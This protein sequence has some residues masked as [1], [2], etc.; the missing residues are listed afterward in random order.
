MPNASDP[1]ARQQQQPQPQ[2]PQQ[3]PQQQPQYQ[4]PQPGYGYAGSEANA[5][6]ISSDDPVIQAIAEATAEASRRTSDPEV[7]IEQKKI[8]KRIVVQ[9]NSSL[10]ELQTNAENGTFRITD[11]DIWRSQTRYSGNA[12]RRSE[13]KKGN[14]QNV[15]LHSIRRISYRNDFPCDIGM[16]IPGIRTARGNVFMPDGDRYADLFH[17]DSFSDASF[18][19]VK[20]SEFVHAPYLYLYPGYN[21]S[22]TDTKNV[23]RVKGGNGQNRVMVSAAPPERAHP[24]LAILE[25]DPEM[26]SFLEQ[27]PLFKPSPDS[28]ISYVF[29][30]EEP[31]DRAN[32]ELKQDLKH[33][34]P[35][36]NLENLEPQFSRPGRDWKSPLDF[37]RNSREVQVHSQKYLE[38]H[39]LLVVYEIT[40]RFM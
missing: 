6:T 38:R 19:V 20:E 37:M 18:E 35:I 7:Q 32:E 14:I 13:K 36:E 24:A 34:L 9:I 23:R 39:N 10:H 33:H 21:P 15:V 11:Y 3:Q 8:T 16:K 26:A 22:N 30:P 17:K 2:Y 12:T 5:G 31:F 1:N 28:E 25:Q 29:V 4:Q 40:Y 27:S